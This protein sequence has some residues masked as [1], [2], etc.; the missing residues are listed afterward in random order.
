MFIH[1]S[2]LVSTANSK[3]SP[4]YSIY[5]YLGSWETPYSTKFLRDKNLGKL[6]LE[7]AMGQTLSVFLEPINYA[8]QCRDV[9]VLTNAMNIEAP[10]ESA[11][12][13]L[14]A[15]NLKLQ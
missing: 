15:F 2:S 14:E 4:I 1:W 13:D 9:S 8:S 11:P 7:L 10:Y 12:Q 5:F 6:R 3:I